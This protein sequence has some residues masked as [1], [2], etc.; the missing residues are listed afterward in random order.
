MRTREEHRYNHR[1]YSYIPPPPDI[2]YWDESRT[3]TEII[4]ICKSCES[5][6]KNNLLQIEENKKKAKKEKWLNEKTNLTDFYL[7]R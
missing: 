3:D 2:N 4:Y 7:K 5:R 6:H 1:W